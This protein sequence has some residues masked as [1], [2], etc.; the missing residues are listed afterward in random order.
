MIADIKYC[1]TCGALIS[2]INNADWYSHIAKQYCTDCR[3]NSDR[4][5]TA[6]RVYNLRQRKKIKDK[7]RD[8]Q[9]ILLQEENKLLK[10]QNLQ[11]RE[12]ILHNIT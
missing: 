6:I 5:K 10:Q 8:E 7:Y 3:K 11:L 2:D 9:L 4:M 12:K 1:K